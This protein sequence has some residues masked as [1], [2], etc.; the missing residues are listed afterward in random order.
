MPSAVE[1]WLQQ[2]EMLYQAALQEYQAIA[3]K[4]DTMEQ[5]LV[6]KQAE[7]NQIA[8]II[9]KPAV[10][11]GRR[12]VAQ[13]VASPVIEERLPSVPGNSNAN[14]ARALAGRFGR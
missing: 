11:G 8:A 12:A 2:G 4:L 3:A 10:E 5:Q 1:Q 13:V 9:G 14:I 7:V 6:A